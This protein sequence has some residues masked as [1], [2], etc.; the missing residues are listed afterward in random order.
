[1]RRVVPAVGLFLLAPLVAEFLLGDVPVTAI[2]ALALLSPI[3]GGG[4]LLIREVC[5]RAGWGWPS[6]ATLA[7]AYGLVEEGV[8]TQ[9]LFNPHYADK[10]LLSY[11]HID[12]LGMGASWTVFVLVL[13]MVWSIGVPIAVAELLTPGRRTTPWLGRVGLAVTAVLY[14]VGLAVIGVST[15]GQSRF[16]ASAGQLAGVVVAAAALVVLAVVLGRRRTR[17]QPHASWVPRPA[18]LVVASAFVTSEVTAHWYLSKDHMSSWLYVGLVLVAVAVTVS[19]LVVLSRRAGWRPAHQLALVAGA[20]V[21]YAWEG[22]VTSHML[23]PASPTVQLVSHVVFALGALVL[24]VV[25][26]VRLRRPAT[27]THAAPVPTASP[28]R[29]GG[30]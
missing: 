15:Y 6:I 17:R 2:V 28:V 19:I 9:S 10:H 12:A 11:G 26:A 1:M 3:Y 18:V 29:Q 8:A 7:L 5:R 13:H 27:P 14:A 25:T 22:F 16:M 23:F 24:I 20:L 4:A 30:R 21:T